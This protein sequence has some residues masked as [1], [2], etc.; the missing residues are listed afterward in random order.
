MA[1]ST[2]P[3]PASVPPRQI[4]DIQYEQLMATYAGDG[5]S[6]SP[7][8]TAPVYADSTGRHLKLRSN[9]YGL[10]R[11]RMWAS[12]PTDVTKPVTANAS[13]ATR[14]DLLVLRL[15]RST[16]RVTSEVKAGVGLTLPA[17]QQDPDVA[18][19][20]AGMWEIPL[21]KATVVDGATTINPDQCVPIP[22]YLSYP[23][24]SCTSTTRPAIKPGMRIYEYDTG[25]RYYA[26]GSTWLKIATELDAV[27]MIYGYRFTGTSPYT[28]RQDFGRVFTTTLNL[29]SGHVYEPQVGLTC[30][31]AD[32]RVPATF[33]VYLYANGVPLV[34][35]GH[36]SMTFAGDSRRVQI[37]NPLAVATT[38][39]VVFE[40]YLQRAA[41]HVD[42][43]FDLF[44]GAANPFW[45]KV[46]DLGTSA[47]YTAVG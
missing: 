46:L 4:N 1:E 29:Q 13:G 37:G 27:R 5:L 45:F 30:Y 34:D 31:S 42:W 3:D 25:A 21:A 7:G 23:E 22:W 26:A 10:V 24:V 43:R 11:G 17:L 2:W 28:N 14:M 18:G 32:T 38:G 36:Q 39:P 44:T 47:N 41:G 6:G 9:K 19:A 12:G 35:S 16:W 33:G 15:T 20:G 8:D 40:V